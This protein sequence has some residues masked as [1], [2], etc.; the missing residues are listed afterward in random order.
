MPPKSPRSTN[1]KP[2]QPKSTQINTANCPSVYREQGLIE[3][4]R[5]SLGTSDWQLPPEDLAVLC[6][7][8]CLQSSI[9]S[10]LSKIVFFYV[11]EVDRLFTLINSLLLTPHN[12]AH[13]HCPTWPPELSWSWRTPLKAGGLGVQQSLSLDCH[14][15]WIEG[16]PA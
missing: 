9:Q 6:K 7:P 2:G 12:W 16:C 4:E 8:G 1:I 14:E 5:W 10:S 11:L 3:K 13:F 15:G